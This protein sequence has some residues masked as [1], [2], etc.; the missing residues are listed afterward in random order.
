M[1]F[2]LS[3][4]KFSNND[5]K[6]NICIPASMTPKLAE[7]L[8]IIVGDGHVA[9]YRNNPGIHSYTNYEIRIDKKRAGEDFRELLY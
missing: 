5:L 6:R 9:C 1:K 8:G 3:K 2:D 4:I 7:F